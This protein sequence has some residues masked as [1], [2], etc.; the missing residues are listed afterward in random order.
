MIELIRATTNDIPVIRSLAT[1]IWNEHYISII[2]QEQIDY[3]LQEW[4]AETTLFRQMTEQGH[5]FW[6]INAEPHQ[7]AVG[8]IALTSQLEPGAYYLN[9]F[10]IHSR[11][12]GIGAEVFRRITAQLPDITQLRLNVNRRNFKSVNFYF[13]MGFVIESCYELPVG[14]RFRMDDFIMVWH[15]NRLAG[16][17]TSTSL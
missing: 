14:D 8:F 12:R 17:S 3:M 6:L 9:K 2:T 11:A 13:K 1:E 16:A 5:F 10:Y 4:Y 15:K 7:G